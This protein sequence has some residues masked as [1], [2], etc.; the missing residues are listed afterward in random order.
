MLEN[1]A[2]PPAQRS[3]ARRRHA[4]APTARLVQ[5]QMAVAAAM[6]EAGRM[7]QAAATRAVGAVRVRRRQPMR[8]GRRSSPESS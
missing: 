2:R 3:L 6:D 1:G 4:G 5:L 7:Q 8:E